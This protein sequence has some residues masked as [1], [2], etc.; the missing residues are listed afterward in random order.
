MGTNT[1]STRQ[2]PAN[3][4]TRSSGSVSGVPGGPLLHQLDGQMAPRRP[5]PVF[6]RHFAPGM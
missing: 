6:A 5:L 4:D 2:L 3:L 1:S